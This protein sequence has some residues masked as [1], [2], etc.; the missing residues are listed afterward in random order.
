MGNPGRRVAIVVPLERSEQLDQFS[1]FFIMPRYGPMAIATKLK[2]CGYELRVFSEFARSNIDYDYVLS[3]DYI[4]F[5]LMSF[6][7]TKGYAIADEIRKKVDKPIIFGGCH[8]SVLPE[9]CLE[10]CDYVVRNE[11]EETLVDL[12]DAIQKGSDLRSVRG[13]SYKDENGAMFHNQAREFMQDIDYPVDM[14]LLHDYEPTDLDP[15]EQ[16][17]KYGSVVYHPLQTSRGCPHNCAFCHTP[18]D[19]GTRYRMKSIDTVITDIRNARSK[20]FIFVDTDFTL[21]RVRTKQLLERMIKEFDGKLHITAFSRIEVSQDVELLTLMKRAGVKLLY[22]GIESIDEDTL[23]AYNKGQD[24]R[25]IDECVG[26]IHSCGIHTI[27]TFMFGSD[28]DTAQTLEETVDY[29]IEKGFSNIAL[30]PVYD[31]PTQARVIQAPQMFPDNRFIHNDW[32]FFNANFVIHY[33]KRMKPSTLQRGIMDGYLKFHSWR[34]ALFP[35]YWFLGLP[36]LLA[37]PLRFYPRHYPGIHFL[38]DEEVFGLL[39]R[40]LFL[41]RPIMKT[42]RKYVRVLERFEEG[43]YDEDER[44]IE[45]KLPRIED[46]C[47]ER[48]ISLGP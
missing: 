47:P 29:A 3:S 27:A 39:G 17:V 13:I 12:L 42:M 25:K 15:L 18:R 24:F 20:V 45:E 26:V 35:R 32:R 19:L 28:H 38:V 21:N 31:F 7:A 48:R 22:L 11:G 23:R 8:A 34:R 14:T 1:P 46:L 36:L 40:R 16:Y 2:N 9:D 10:H 5:S 33:P 44:L 6:C 37:R 41:L 30:F 43:L 4:C